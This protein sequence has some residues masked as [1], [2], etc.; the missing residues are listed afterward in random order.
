M[1]DDFKE[2]VKRILALRAGGKCSNPSCRCS[3]F[4][5]RTEQHQIVNIG[6]AAHIH[7]ASE[8]GPRYDRNMLNE[9]RAS[10][11]NAIWLCQSCAKLIDNDEKRYTPQLLREWKAGAEDAAIRELERRES[12]IHATAAT[13]ET[14]VPTVHIKLS[15]VFG[16]ITPPNDF[17]LIINRLSVAAAKEEPLKLHVELVDLEKYAAAFQDE[18][19]Q[20]N[21]RADRLKKA[22]QIAGAIQLLCSKAVQDWLPFVVTDSADRVNVAHAIVVWYESGHAAPGTKLDV[23]RDRPPQLSAPVYLSEAEV[24]AMLSKFEFDSMRDLAMGAGWRAADELPT[25]VILGKVLPRILIET[26]IKNINPVQVPET[27]VLASW[28]IGQG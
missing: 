10:I 13:F 9:D 5:P 16:V 12:A 15:P 4:G 1:R 2:E 28:H 23:W 26:Q 17:K 21:F 14:P 11:S 6:V 8:G 20:V 3:T 19:H 22:A 27:L 18:V 7:A 24:A 25:E